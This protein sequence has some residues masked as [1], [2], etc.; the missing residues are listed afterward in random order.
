M[1]AP[2]TPKRL[3]PLYK[4]AANGRKRSLVCCEKTGVYRYQ[5]RYAMRKCPFQ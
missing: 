1:N 3:H 2:G 5:M 4:G